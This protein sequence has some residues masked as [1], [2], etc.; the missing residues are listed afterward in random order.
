M[1]KE[2]RAEDGPVMDGHKFLLAGKCLAFRN[3]YF[4]FFHRFALSGGL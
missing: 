2:T 3:D 4:H 1:A